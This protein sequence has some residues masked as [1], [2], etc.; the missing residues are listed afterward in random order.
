[1]SLSAGAL[2]AIGILL[3]GDF[4][5]TEGRILTTTALIAA[6][7][8][9]TLPAAILVDQGRLLALATLVLLLA[10]G[11]LLLAL[12]AVW[13]GGDSEAL[14]R[15]MGTVT[16]LAIAATQTAALAA[17]AGPRDPRAV[18][19]LFRASVVLAVV[20]AGLVTAAIWAEV[21]DERYLRVVGALVVLDVLLV[22]LQPILALA[23]PAAVVYRLRLRVAPGGE[24]EATVEAADFPAAAA[25]AI[26]DAERAGHR[27]LALERDEHARS[28]SRDAAA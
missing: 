3:F 11:G 7:A 2:L 19:R 15:T 26:R 1:M 17:R 12:V 25:K 9:L 10:G 23:R 8:L 27:V 24:I 16:V 28:A 18:R 4:G 22:A 13:G 20:L 21:G 5:E 6:Y 14:G